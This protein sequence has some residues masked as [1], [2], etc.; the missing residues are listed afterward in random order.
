ML[1][2]TCVFASSPEV[3]HP[4]EQEAR[5]SEGSRGTVSPGPPAQ[6]PGKVWAPVP[7]GPVPAPDGLVRCFVCTLEPDLPFPL[8]VREAPCYIKMVNRRGLV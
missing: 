1:H 8:T 4:Q 5:G 2:P 6:R 3:L 7:C